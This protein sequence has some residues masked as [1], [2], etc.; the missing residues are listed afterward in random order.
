VRADLKKL[1]QWLK[2][3]GK[4]KSGDRLLERGRGGHSRIMSYFQPLK[5]AKGDKTHVC[6]LC[7]KTYTLKEKGATT[8]AKDHLSSQHLE[9]LGSLDNLEPYTAK[10]SLAG[11]IEAGFVRARTAAAAAATTQEARSRQLRL[12]AVPSA[13]PSQSR[14]VEN[15][16]MRM[17]TQHNLPFNMIE[18]EWLHELVEI[19]LLMSPCKVCRG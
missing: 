8:N 19:L 14:L 6:V 1:E 16:L 13:T 5:P 3:E 7:F 18:W 11:T 17:A 15:V 12:T 10:R 4:L 9:E 2:N